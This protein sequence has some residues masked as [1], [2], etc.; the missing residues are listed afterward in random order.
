[1]EDTEAE[2]RKKEARAAERAAAMEAELEEFQ[3]KLASGEIKR[4]AEPVI[5]PHINASIWPVEE[6]KWAMG[7]L[8]LCE[9]LLDTKAPSDAI[10]TWQDSKGVKY[11]LRPR[12]DNSPVPPYDPANAPL[13]PRH[14]TSAIF[15]IGT[16]VLVKVRWAPEGWP[17]SEG[18]AIRLVREK[19]PE[20]PVPEAIHFWF[21]REWARYFLIVRRVHGKTL[22]KAWF[23]LSEPDKRR[24]A[25]EVARY[26]R[27]A[28]AITSPLFQ[29]ANGEPLGDYQLMHADG[30]TASFFPVYGGWPGPFTISEFRKFLKDTSD[31]VDPPE[32]DSQFHLYQGDPTPENIIVSGSETSKAADSEGGVSQVHVA[33]IIDWERAGFYPDFWSLLHPHVPMGG[34]ELSITWE[35]YDEDP[36]VMGDYIDKLLSG[37]VYGDGCE[38]FERFEALGEWWGKFEEGRNRYRMKKAQARLKAEAAQESRVE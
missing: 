6:G 14:F 33:G 37:L 29:Q 24:V 31:G 36:E 25:S 1:M 19:A 16:D 28:A 35:Q 11:C 23:T 20:V 27:Q 3:A 2:K 10:V 9:R 12:K 26:I 34:F 18:D 7:N 32:F 15:E 22:D 17:R 21:D 4:P 38:N 30:L 13:I 8:M 5:E